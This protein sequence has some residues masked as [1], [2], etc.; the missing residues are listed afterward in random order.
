MRNLL[1]YILFNI[2]AYSCTIDQGVSDIITQKE[3]YAKSFLISSKITELSSYDALNVANN[4]V[5]QYFKTKSRSS[6]LHIASDSKIIIDDYGHVIAYI[7]NFNKGGFCVISASKSNFP[8]LAYSE[9]ES[10]IFDD[11]SDNNAISLWIADLINQQSD[12]TEQESVESQLALKRSWMM[13][14]EHFDTVIATKSN[15][16]PALINAFNQQLYKY[17]AESGKRGIPLS[18]AGSILPPNIY[19]ALIAAAGPVNHNFIIVEIDDKPIKNTIGP[20]LKTEWNQWPPFN[21]A[22]EDPQC[23]AGCV[24]IAMGQIMKYHEY[25]SGYDWKSMDNIF[26]NNVATLVAEIGRVTKVNYKPNGSGTD[27]KKIVQ[28]FTHYKY[29]IRKSSYRVF[30]VFDEVSKMR[31]PVFMTGSKDD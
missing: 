17:R 20:L 4:F 23:P 8:V 14:E 24:P 27:L 30:D 9:D 31:I 13:Y 26:H 12:F 10:L 25:P 29:N 6:F 7:F 18:S 21:N 28:G 22:I 11:V 3:P 5:N 16:D 1:L 15:V 19:S 2:L